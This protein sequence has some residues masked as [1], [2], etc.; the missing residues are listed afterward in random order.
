[1]KAS[2]EVE[3]GA[4]HSLALKMGFARTSRSNA[5]PEF[6]DYKKAI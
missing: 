4:S 2:V 1:M 6:V 3:N 5:E